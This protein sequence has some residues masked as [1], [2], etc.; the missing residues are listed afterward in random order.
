MRSNS[1][2]ADSIDP[3]TS[4]PVQDGLESTTVIE[5]GEPIDPS[6]ETT[7]TNEQ[8][9]G[10]TENP[11]DLGVDPLIIVNSEDG[12]SDGSSDSGSD[13]VSGGSDVTNKVDVDDL[14]KLAA[15]PYNGR[16]T[17]AGFSLDKHSQREGSVY[18]SSSR[19]A[20]VQ[21]QEA[22]DIV[23]DILTTPGTQFINKTARKN[24]Q[25]VSV[26]DAVAPDG[27]TF[28]FD[29]SRNNLSGFREPN[30]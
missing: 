11:S 30:R 22:Q 20:G 26:I 9:L 24:G 21:N 28:R 3:S 8:G 2:K 27:R 29:S 23:D 17:R 4:L 14:S 6:I 12:K 19:K 10:T 18:S 7:A 15:K 25:P 1:A 13:K 16:R 5:S